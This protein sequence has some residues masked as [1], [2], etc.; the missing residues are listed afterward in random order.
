MQNLSLPKIPVQEM[1]YWRQLS[2]SVF[3]IHDIKTE[4]SA[5]FLYHEE[6]AHKGPNE[7]C[8]FLDYYIKNNISS[9]VDELHLYSDNCGGQNKNHTLSRMLLALTDIGRFKKIIQNFPVRGHSFLPCDR[10]FALIKRYLKKKRSNLYTT[11]V[12]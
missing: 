2:V 9:S 11:P 10:D 12:Y 5:I 4:K 6:Q 1:F 8:S 3:C 7:V